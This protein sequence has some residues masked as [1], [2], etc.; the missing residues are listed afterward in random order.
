MPD[1]SRELN[2]LLNVDKA[3]VPKARWII[4]T[5]CQAL[6]Y[7]CRFHEL[8]A[9]ER[10]QVYY[11]PRTETPYPVKIRHSPKAAAFFAGTADLPDDQLRFFQYGSEMLPF[12]FSDPGEIFHVDGQNILIHKDIVASAFYFLSCWQEHTGP[13]AEDGRFAYQRSLQGRWNLA[14]VPFVDRYAELF[15]HAVSI[16]LPQTRQRPRWPEERPF[17]VSL[18]HDLDY[19][20]YWS[21]HQLAETR[22]YNTQRLLRSPLNAGWKLLG[23][24]LDKRFFYHP[25]RRNGGVIQYEQRLGLHSTSFIL[26]DAEQKDERQRYL[27]EQGPEL[28]DFLTIINARLVQLHGAGQASFDEKTL[29]GQLRNMAAAG[30]ACRGYRAHRLMVDYDVTLPLL[31]RNGLVYDSSLGWWEHIGYR[32]GISTPFRPFDLDANKPL[33]LLEIPLVVMDT[34]L[35]SR[36]AM[37]LSPP[38]ALHR[39]RRLLHSAARRGGHISLLWHYRTF[40][41][42]DFPA[43][44]RLYREL[45]REARDLGAWVCSL[46]ELY[47]YWNLRIQ[48]KEFSCN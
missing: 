27:M 41:P 13:R 15:Q 4:E 47:D 8:Y 16:A 17:A 34:T 10:V 12:L 40:D 18:S 35:H 25:S 30:Y 32:A 39:L 45:I 24:T 11:G 14:T 37:R 21:A 23:H 33:S 48:D 22:R 1:S 7:C 26:A 36:K 42:I 31:E 5:F 6:G 43:W 19:W 28:K 46:D 29:L 20:N 3:F 9:S 38:M 2:I 44:G